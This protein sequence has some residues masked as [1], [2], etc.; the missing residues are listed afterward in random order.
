MIIRE[1]KEE[2]LLTIAQAEEQIF[3]GSAWDLETFVYEY[4]ENPFS[5]IYVAEEDGKIVAYGDLWIMFEKAQIATIGVLPAYRYKGYGKALM[6]YMLIEAVGQECE[7][8]TLEV[9]QSNAAAISLY[10]LLGFEKVSVRKDYYK[11]N[12]EDAWLM[13]KGLIG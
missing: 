5:A 4:K 10:E 9:R 6:L 1:A 3:T 12:H 7:E 8:M 2:E 11:D 13:V